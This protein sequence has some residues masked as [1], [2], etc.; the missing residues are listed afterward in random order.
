VS[1]CTYPRCKCIVS[2]STEQP[3]PDCPRNLPR[4]MTFLTG[5]PPDMRYGAH[6]EY[7]DP[8]VARAYGPTPEAAIADYLDNYS[9]E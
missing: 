6:H 4:V 3:E 7:A 2:T 9:E 1:I 8:P 5:G